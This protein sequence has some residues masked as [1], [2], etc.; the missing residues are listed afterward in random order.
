MEVVIYT[1]SDVF[2]PE[3]QTVLTWES[4]KLRNLTNIPIRSGD[5]KVDRAC[6]QAKMMWEGRE[7]FP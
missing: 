6:W 2:V 1:E 7:S 4:E 5:G 3:N